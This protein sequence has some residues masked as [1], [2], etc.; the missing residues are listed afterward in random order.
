MYEAFFGLREPAFS[1]TPDPR[2]LWPSE[3]HEEG[4]DALCYGIESRRG[5]LL[6]TGEVGAGKTTLLR[7]ALERLSPGTDT[8]LVMNTAGLGPLD[9]FKLITRELG[10]TGRFESKADYVIALN[11]FLLE[12]L[13]DG[14]N[15]VLIVDEAQNLDAGALEE[16]RLLSNL[17]TDTHKLLQIVLTGQPE[18]RTALQAPSLRPLRQRIALEHHVESL[19]P[20]EARPYLAHRIGVAGGRLDEVFEPGVEKIFY[21]FSGGCPRLMNLLADRCLLAAYGK[22]LRPVP[23]RLV[24]AKA[25]RMRRSLLGPAAEASEG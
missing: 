11:A 6:L 5:F 14:R 24:E 12:R 20:E 1:L 25:A 7:A 23:T 19:S 16:V 3:T 18:L 15:V 17:E 22:D 4:L 9:L 10:V 8:A 13:S 21:E 2:F